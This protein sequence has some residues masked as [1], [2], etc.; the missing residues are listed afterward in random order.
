MRVASRGR[1]VTSKAS[2]LTSNIWLHI[3]S[4]VK[5]R[6]AECEVAVAYFGDRASKLL[7]LKKGS[8]LVVDMSERAVRSG[9]TKPSELLSLIRQGVS[10][11]SVQ[12]L[13]AKLFVAGNTAIIGSPNASRRSALTLIEAAIL[14][15]DRYVVSE[16]REF[17][18]SLTG[19]VVTAQLAKAMQKL[20]SPP[21]FA[22]RPPPGEPPVPLHPPLWVAWLYT[23]P[24][25]QDLEEAE[26]GWL[27]AKSISCKVRVRRKGKR[28]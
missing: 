10:V 16:S 5:R 28:Q 24:T 27:H 12:N 25:E 13:H 26:E 4:A 21:K 8:T 2:L 14:I 1:H 11:H 20:Y 23:K 18:R 6:P 7:P 15:R 9:Q 17:I 19:E 22:P 3:T